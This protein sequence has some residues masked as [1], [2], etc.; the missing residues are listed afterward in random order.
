[1][2]AEDKP[3]E[4][5]RETYQRIA[6]E[7]MKTATPAEAKILQRVMNAWHQIEQAPNRPVPEIAQRLGHF[8]IPEHLVRDH[9]H[10]VAYALHGMIITRCE[11][12]Y[13]SHTFHY[14]AMGPQFRMVTPDALIP[15]YDLRIMINAFDDASIPPSVAINEW[16][17]KR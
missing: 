4:T 17:G 12:D 9:P 6:A 1:M 15:H 5:V 7:V 10:A 8:A 3:I 2:M 16:Q 13:A 14:T 11:Y